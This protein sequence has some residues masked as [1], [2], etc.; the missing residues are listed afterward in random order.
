LHHAFASFAFVSSVWL[1][2]LDPSPASKKTRE[3]ENKTMQTHMRTSSVRGIF[4][5][6]RLSSCYQSAQKKE[7][8][9]GKSAE[10]W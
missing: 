4:H 10:S 6:Y 7:K 2:G 5:R 8:Y 3:N 1:A 9:P